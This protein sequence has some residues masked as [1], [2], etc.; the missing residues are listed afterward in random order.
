MTSPQSLIFR[1]I[2]S[3][4]LSLPLLHKVPNC[5]LVEKQKVDVH[6]PYIWSQP[7]CW[8]EYSSDDNVKHPW[9]ESSSR[10]NPMLKCRYAKTNSFISDLD[11]LAGKNTE[12]SPKTADNVRHLWL[13]SSNRH[14]LWVCM[15][16]DLFFIQSLSLLP[17]ILKTL[18]KPVIMSDTCGWKAATDRNPSSCFECRCACVWTSCIYSLSLA[19]RNTEDSPK[20]SGN[21]TSMVGK[22]VFKF[23]VQLCNVHGPPPYLVSFSTLLALLAR[24]LNSPKTNENENVHGW[25]AA[26]DTNPS[27]SFECRCAWIS[28]LDGRNTEDSPMKMSFTWLES[29]VAVF[30]PIGLWSQHSAK[31]PASSGGGGSW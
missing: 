21:I 20:T 30:P 3:Q 26:T 14:K 17:R 29:I 12:N 9:L 19:G 6:R 2:N 1:C 25:K 23:W 10:I 15:W 7:S 18:R 11:P 28:S 27:L 5:K 22:P 16:M 31:S 4:M 24:K 8:Q 13:E